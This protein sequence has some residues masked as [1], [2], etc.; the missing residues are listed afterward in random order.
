MRQFLRTQEL[1]LQ[2]LLDEP[3]ELNRVSW[4]A[5]MSVQGGVPSNPNVTEL[6]KFVRP[7]DGT[8]VLDPIYQTDCTLPF[9]TDMAD[10]LK[11]LSSTGRAMTGQCTA[12]DVFRV[13]DCLQEHIE[14][15]RMMQ[16]DLCQGFASKEASVLAMLYYANEQGRK[17]CHDL[18]LL[19]DSDTPQYEKVTMM[20]PVNMFSERTD[21]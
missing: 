16:T 19:A 2:R 6:A 5:Y 12:E 7:A 10:T 20:L 9:T 17:L 1:G 21:G 4:S 14:T 8:K 15:L 13:R 3:D 18:Q 11:G